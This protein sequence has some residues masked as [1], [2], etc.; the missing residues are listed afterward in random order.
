MHASL[1]RLKGTRTKD[2]N[3]PENLETAN[4]STRKP[5]LIAP[6]IS[7]P[8]K[9]CPINTYT[10]KALSHH[11]LCPQ[12]I[13]SS[14]PIPTKYCPINIYT[15]KVLFHQYIVPSVPTNI[16]SLINTNKIFFASNI[17]SSGRSHV[18]SLFTIEEQNR[19]ACDCVIRL[20]Y[21]PALFMTSLILTAGHKPAALTA[22]FSLLKKMLMFN[23]QDQKS[24]EKLSGAN[25][26]FQSYR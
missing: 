7:T 17:T 5:R 20:P 24:S 6:S 9:H 25:V 14:T 4:I 16:V 10:N 1:L 12:S 26:S 15:N 2:P 22:V 13:V 11:Y 19:L 8:T 3:W 23:K 18:R 21:S